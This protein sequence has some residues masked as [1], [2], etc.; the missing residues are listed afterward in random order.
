AFVDVET[1]GLDPTSDRIAE[2]GVVTL[3]GDIATEWGT[4]VAPRRGA[5]P[6][7]P[8]A[9]SFLSTPL[10]DVAPTFRD[11]AP[12][13]ARRLAGRLLVAHNAR[14]DHAFLKAEFER[15]GVAF[16]APIVCTVM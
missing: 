3:D 1:T 9:G 6:R 12:E 2:V 15:A 11:I 16:D 8:R 14:F 10:P 13:L 4:F 7:G 5:H